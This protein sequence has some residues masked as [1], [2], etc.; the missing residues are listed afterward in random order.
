MGAAP[1]CCS[2]YIDEMYMKNNKVMC[3]GTRFYTYT[4]KRGKRLISV[5]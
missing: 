3:E 1:L 5:G 4:H 2:L